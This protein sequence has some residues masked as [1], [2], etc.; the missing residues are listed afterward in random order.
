MLQKWVTALPVAIAKL[1]DGW[2][3]VTYNNRKTGN[4]YWSNLLFRK[5]IRHLGSFRLHRSFQLPVRLHHFA[6]INTYV[7]SYSLL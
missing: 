1:R 4:W 7:L 5:F 2:D 6:R 3:N